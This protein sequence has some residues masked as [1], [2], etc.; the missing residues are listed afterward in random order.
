MHDELYIPPQLSRV[1]SDAYR[2]FEKR[3]KV[4]DEIMTKLLE[5]IL[6]SKTFRQLVTIKEAKF[7]YLED[8]RIFFDEYTLPPH[9]EII[10]EVSRQI[11]AQNVP[12]IFAGGTGNGTFLCFKWKLTAQILISSKETR[13][14]QTITGV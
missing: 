4:P 6:D 5:F 9:G 12:I 8:G 14:D 11:V 13:N 3:Q 1:F 2:Y 7:V 10:G